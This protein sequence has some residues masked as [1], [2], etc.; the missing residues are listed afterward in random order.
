MQQE[1]EVSRS[2]ISFLQ[3]EV[4]SQEDRIDELHDELEDWQQKCMQAEHLA[5]GLRDKLLESHAQAKETGKAVTQETTR[6]EALHEQNLF[7][8]KEL[9]AG[10]RENEGLQSQ[11]QSVAA[12]KD[13]LEE[14][15]R[16][17]KTLLEDSSAK[18][19]VTNTEKEQSQ[20]QRQV[21]EQQIQALEA[22]NKTL[23]A[24]SSQTATKGQDP[25]ESEVT[26]TATQAEEMREVITK[27]MKTLKE[28]VANH[29]ALREQKQSLETE[30][31]AR[32]EE[33]VELRAQ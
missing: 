11:L 4:C 7:L 21:L 14:Q 23:Q 22:E 19:A 8:E 20:L 29:E 1:L 26:S 15:V 3:K 13:H 16:S 25:G 33:F 32:T 18:E 24:T 17:L 27:E 28:Y 2:L 9:E 12:D 31:R 10:A 30:V 6:Y 5:Q